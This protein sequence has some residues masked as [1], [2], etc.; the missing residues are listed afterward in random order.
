M[1]VTIVVGNPKA[2]SRTYQAAKLV[3][4]KLTDR[5]ADL[6][7]DL[8]DLGAAIHRSM[9]EKNAEQD[10]DTEQPAT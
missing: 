5:P 8:A 10:A 4:E 2:R 3:A 9:E 6:V 1:N 7:I